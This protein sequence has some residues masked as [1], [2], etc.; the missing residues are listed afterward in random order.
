M[1]GGIRGLEPPTMDGIALFLDLDGTLAPIAA[2]PDAIVLDFRVPD[3]LPRLAE[4]LSG[5]VAIIS[6]RSLENVD[7]I[8][9]GSIVPVAGVHG[10]ER[11]TASGVRIGIPAHPRLV[12]AHE[13]FLRL[14][15][16]HPG[17]LVEDKGLGVAL[18]YRGAPE[19]AETAPELGRRLAASTGLALQEGD[20]VVELLTPGQD[21]G[22]AVLAFMTEAP[23]AGGVPVFVGDDLTDEHA[24][25]I[26]SA[27]GGF[28]IRVGPERDTKARYRLANVDAVIAWL[29][30]LIM[31]STA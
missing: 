17:L 21:K 29:Q 27:S 11:R 7:R 26:V 1:I 24:F 10:L 31:E 15:D 9:S 6:G 2:T 22:A 13:E 18:H 5:R 20:M 3:L 28:G 4:K 25:A 23:F 19:F 30:T 14:A 8:L 12:Q 16:V